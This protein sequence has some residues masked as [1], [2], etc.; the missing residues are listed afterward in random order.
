MKTDILF[1]E[2]LEILVGIIQFGLIALV[3]M[4]LWNWLMPAMFTLP[5]L[6][7]WQACGMRALVRFFIASRPDRKQIMQ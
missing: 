4:L 1:N 2:L 6:T 7:Y 3:L 5:T